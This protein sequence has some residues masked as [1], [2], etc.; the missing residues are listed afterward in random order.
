[1]SSKKGGLSALLIRHDSDALISPWNLECD[2]CTV[3]VHVF[4]DRLNRVRFSR[5]DGDPNSSA[6]KGA[7]ES[8]PTKHYASTLQV[9]TSL[10]MR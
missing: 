3:A 9:S 2:T 4:G 7:S 1:M 10:T 6:E 8:W 5:Q